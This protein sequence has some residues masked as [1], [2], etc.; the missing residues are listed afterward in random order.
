MKESE[1]FTSTFT[2]KTYKMWNRFTC[3]SSY[4]VYLITCS[5]CQ[6]QYVGKSTNTMMQRHGGHRNEIRG[7]LSPLGR[8]FAKCG[9]DNLILQ[10]IAG[11]KP[12]E[13]EALD[14]A[15][16]CWI[17]RLCTLETQ[18]G[19]NSLDERTKI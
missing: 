15:E 14:I 6:A 7:L 11:V 3:Y 8:H 10:I 13:D 1:T 12:G 19:I 2:G 5:K 18:G 16:G 4:V 17:S 9:I